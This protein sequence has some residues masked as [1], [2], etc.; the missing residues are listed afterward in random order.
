MVTPFP[1]LM[2]ALAFAVLAIIVRLV[3]GV[4]K[5]VGAVAA[6]SVAFFALAFVLRLLEPKKNT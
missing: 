4:D 2:M 5:V 6:L 3:G 1:L